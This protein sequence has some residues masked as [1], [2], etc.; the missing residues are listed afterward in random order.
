MYVVKRGDRWWFRKAVPV[1]LVDVLGIAEVRR[2]LHTGNAREARR[3]GLEVLVRVEDVYAVLRSERPIRPARDVALAMLERA[4]DLT[5]GSP[6]MGALKADL[7]KDAHG[8]LRRTGDSDASVGRRD[9]EPRQSGIDAVEPGIA[10]DLLRAEKPTGVENSIAVA[11]L[12]AVARIGHRVLREVGAGVRALDEALGSLSEHRASTAVTNSVPIQIESLRALLATT[13]ERLHA[14]PSPSPAPAPAVDPQALYEM[15]A[16]GAR[17]G[18]VQAEA[19]RWSAMPLSEAIKRYV[20]EEVSKLPGIKHREDV[21]R[22]LQ[23]FLRAVGDKPIR[24]ITPGDLKAYRN[25]LDLMPDRYAARFKTNDLAKA[26]EL[27]AKRQH[28]YRRNGPITVNLKYLGPVRRLFDFLISEDFLGSN[29][30]AKVHSAQKEVKG[31]KNKRHPLKVSQCNAFLACTAGYPLPSSTRWI[32]LIML[33]AGARPNELAQLQVDDLRHDFNGRPHLNVLTLEDDDA[34]AGPDAQKAKQQKEDKRLVKTAAGRRMIPIHPVLIEM[35]LLDLFERRRKTTGKT[36]ALL[37][38]DVKCD[39]YGHYGR[40]VSR[41]LNRRLRE[42]GI[43]NQRISLYSLRH[44][45]RDACIEAGMPDQARF[46]MMGHALKGMDGIY[47]AALLSPSESNWIDKAAYEGLDLGP[48]RVLRDVVSGR[49]R[50]FVTRA[51]ERKA[52]QATEK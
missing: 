47:G 5:S 44:T 21:P 30:A 6:A 17:T 23:T 37:F 11:I 40:E 19:E 15:A 7:I 14:A 27:N 29:P 45:F 32:P 2:S 24:E 41:R 35:G 42:I 3:R 51:F 33:F 48:Y 28:P 49:R 50:S 10:L 31:A 18:L 39:A 22:R 9:F 26:I 20:T 52:R 8:I 25:Q 12:E 4:L 34:D 1:D 36:N 13:L 46:K 16:A 38:P 43:T